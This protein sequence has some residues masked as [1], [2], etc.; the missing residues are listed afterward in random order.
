[1]NAE[2]LKPVLQLLIKQKVIELKDDQYDLNLGQSSF[3]CPLQ[4][5]D[6]DESTIRTGFKSKKIRVMLNAPVKSESKAE[7]ADVLKHVDEDR[8]ML[9][10]AIIVR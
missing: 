4:C 10:Q 5:D 1:M 7:S 3:S 6:A 2:N 9:I 8:K